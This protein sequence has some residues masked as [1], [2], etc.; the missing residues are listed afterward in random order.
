MV[1]SS[2]KNQEAMILPPEFP[3]S[4][5]PPIHYSM[6][7]SGEGIPELRRNAPVHIRW[8][9]RPRYSV[10]FCSFLRE[11]LECSG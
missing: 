3:V 1:R 2:S 6:I 7:G 11:D 4:P 9:R 8:L 10:L 5:A